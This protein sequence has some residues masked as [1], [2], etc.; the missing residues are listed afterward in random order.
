MKL[1]RWFIFCHVVF[2]LW[3]LAPAQTTPKIK[4]SEPSRSSTVDSTFEAEHL[5]ILKWERGYLL[6]FDRARSVAMAIDRAGKAVLISHISPPQ[7]SHVEIRDM[8]AST[9]GG[10]AIAFVGVSSSG[11]FGGFIAWTDHTGNTAQ[12]VQLGSDEPFQIAFAEDG[13]LWAA[14]KKIAENHEE[15]AAYDILRHYGANGNL[16]GTALPRRSLPTA[17]SFPTESASLTASRGRVGFLITMTRTWVE[18]DYSGKE[19]G[20]WVLPG[21]T[22]VI[23]HAF[24]SQSNKVYIRQQERIDKSA[25]VVNSYVFDKSSNTLQQLDTSSVDGGRP[26]GLRGVDGEDLVYL[27]SIHPRLLKWSTPQPSSDLSK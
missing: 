3:S 26:V 27:A 20:R 18:I 25:E 4:L 11:G 7:A 8:S 6:G 9:N 10:F 22:A 21:P 14:V 1:C 24:F 19:L 2:G 23:S 5:A 13:T 15:A 12:L 16:I 17:G